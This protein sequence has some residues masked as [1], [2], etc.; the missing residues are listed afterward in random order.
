MAAKPIR[1][2]F[3]KHGPLV[4]STEADIRRTLAYYAEGKFGRVPI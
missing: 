2:P 1:E 3:V 4:M